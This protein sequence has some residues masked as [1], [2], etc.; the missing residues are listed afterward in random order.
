MLGSCRTNA[1]I[2]NITMLRLFTL[3]LTEQ[4]I[5]VIDVPNKGRSTLWT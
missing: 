3:W 4:L 5:L 2:N 1:A